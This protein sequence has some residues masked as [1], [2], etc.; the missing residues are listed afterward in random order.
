MNVHKFTSEQDA[1][2]AQE[3]VFQAYKADKPQMP[4]KHWEVTVRWA[5]IKERVDAPGE[6]FFQVCPGFED[7]YPVVEDAPSWYPTIE[8]EI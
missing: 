8:E 5:E 6:Y 7:M 3:A 1:I 2:G 4:E